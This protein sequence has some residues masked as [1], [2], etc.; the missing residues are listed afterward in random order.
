MNQV[1][2]MPEPRFRGY[3]SPRMIGVLYHDIE[4]NPIDMQ[5]FVPDQTYLLGT[6]IPPFQRPLVWSDEQK[7]RFIQ[8]AWEG[9]H[10]GT[11][12]VNDPDEMVDGLMHPMQDWLIDGQQR[13]NALLCYFQDHFPVYGACWSEL[14]PTDQRRFKQVEFARTTVRITDEDELRRLYDLMNFGGVAH[15]EEQRAYPAPGGA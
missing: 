10:L 2:R 8:S 4:P 14:T 1:V 6:F 13:L 15:T 7:I 9:L 12:V 5:L 3:T 11:Y